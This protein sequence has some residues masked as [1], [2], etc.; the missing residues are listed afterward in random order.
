MRAENLDHGAE[1]TVAACI[2]YVLTC[3]DSLNNPAHV[4]DA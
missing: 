1:I 3:A 2:K 4:R